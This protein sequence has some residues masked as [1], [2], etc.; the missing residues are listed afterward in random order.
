MVL[1]KR[2]FE[3]ISSKLFDLSRSLECN[4]TSGI[5]DGLNE[6]TYRLP[7][8]SWELLTQY[9]FRMQFPYGNQCFYFACTNG[10]CYCLE[11]SL[12][13]QRN[14]CLLKDFSELSGW[15]FWK[16]S[17]AW[18]FIFRSSSLFT[19]SI[20]QWNE[21]KIF[22]SPTGSPI[23]RQQPKNWILQN[24]NPDENVAGLT[25]ILQARHCRRTI[26]S[27]VFSPS[28]SP[29][30]NPPPGTFKSLMFWLLYYIKPYLSRVE[31]EQSI[32]TS[33]SQIVT[34]WLTYDDASW[35]VT[36]PLNLNMHRRLRQVYWARR[37]FLSLSLWPNIQ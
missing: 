31:T 10:L 24:Q 29:P 26:M 13:G 15:P 18:R 33:V 25:K 14:I 19:D 22:R 8:S 2:E 9:H 1:F 5:G 34:P 3:R 17:W 23:Q 20:N 30:S 28:P 32:M 12:P 21:Y 11:R 27:Q 6:T 7:H 35:R 4:N 16:A 37:R 36:N